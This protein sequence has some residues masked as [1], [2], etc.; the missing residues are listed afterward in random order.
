M[1]QFNC[2]GLPNCSPKGVNPVFPKENQRKRLNVVDITHVT[3]T[4]L[5]VSED[6]PFYPE[7]Q[8]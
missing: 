5:F 6:D 2:D 3:R 1:E 4:L 7:D 8:I